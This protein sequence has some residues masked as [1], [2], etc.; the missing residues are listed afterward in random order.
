MLSVL[1]EKKCNP[2]ILDLC[3]LTDPFR[4]D[5]EGLHFACM[6]KLQ[7]DGPDGLWWLD[8]RSRYAPDLGSR[9][10]LEKGRC[11]RGS[12]EGLGYRGMLQ[13]T[14]LNTQSLQLHYR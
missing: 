10:T 3:L 7:Y 5:A 2:F 4:F 8:W 11:E 12:W 6:A 9:Q 13:A 1:A 14:S